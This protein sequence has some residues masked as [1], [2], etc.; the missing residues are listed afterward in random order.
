MTGLAL[1]ASSSRETLRK[2][3]L[4]RAIGPSLTHFGIV[5]ALTDP[6][7]E[8]HG[9]AGF[10]TIVNNNWR[11]TQE[12]EILAT[13]IAPTI[14]SESAIDATLAPGAYTTIV[15]GNGN[16][17]GVALVEI[18]DLSQGVASKFANLS[19]RAFVSTGENIVIAGFVLSNNAGDD[20]LIVRGLGPSL[21]AFGVPTVL[22]NPT[23]ELR[24]CEGTLIFANDDWRDDPVQAAIIAAA[25]LAP[26]NNLESAIAATL[27][28]GPYTVLFFGQNNG[29]G[30][31]LIEVY[32][33]G[34]A[35]GGP[36]GLERPPCAPA[37]GVT[38]T[39]TPT[40]TPPPGGSCTENFD[41]VTAPALPPGWAATNA[42]GPDPLWITSLTTPDTA[43]NDAVIKDPPEISDKRLETRNIF[44][45]SAAAQ[46]SFRNNYN[47]QN[48][49][50]G[51]VLE[52]SSP[53]IAGGAFTDIT[54]ASVGGSFV[55]G[56]YTSAINA[57]L[58]SPIA[59]RMA[60]SG[61]SGGY[62][63]TVANLGPHVIGQ[64]IKLRFRLGTDQALAVG[65]WRIDTLS[66]TGAS[67]P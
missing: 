55:T 46:L 3:V 1:A 59:G 5:D 64:T 35:T 45:T 41:G 63:N 52:V 36:A 22:A 50:D 56:G 23:L 18:Y 54:N 17:S 28:P 34:T 6:V 43:P 39:P 21:A 25:G 29:T 49:F 37:P 9:P 13:G 33:R 30:I 42:A 2:R 11:D 61:N 48:T 47:L 62:I 27:P 32:D 51:G 15:R 38:P 12:N 20:A 26:S 31:G 7:L 65:G 66:I 67:C 19:T 44:I 14:D 53:N 57:G 8:L 60:W 4:L 58:G 10:A 24:N 40:A 16:T